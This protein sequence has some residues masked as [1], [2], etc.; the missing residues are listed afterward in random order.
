MLAHHPVTGKEVRVLQTDTSL[1]REKKT[2]AWVEPGGSIPPWDT[3]SSGRL[4]GGAWPDFLLS[5]DGL[6][7]P[8][9][10]A[11][12][13]VVFTGSDSVSSGNSLA[14]GS[15]AEIYPHLGPKWD[16]TQEDAIVLIAGL[17]RYR[18]V[19]G[20]WS[21]R[22]TALGLVQE[23]EAPLKLWWIT[24]LFRP[25]TSARRHEIT[26]C[27]RRN[28]ESPLIDRIV[29]LNE[30]PEIFPKSGK[31]TEVIVGKRLRYSTVLEWIA[32]EVPD[33][34][35]VA[36][37]NAD[38]CIDTESWCSLWSVELTGRFLALLRYDVPES[39]DVSEATL[40]GP[41]A[42]SQDT[43]VVKASDIRARGK[44]WPAVNIPFGQMGCDNAVA[45]EMM[46][47]K[48][49]VVNPAR[50]MK[51]WHFHASG[52]RTYVKTDVVDRPTF[53][54]VH[55]SG[56]NDLCPVLKWSE[57]KAGE[58]IHVG[59]R[60][61]LRLGPCFGTAD[62]LVF[63]STRT[64]VGP[65]VETQKV[66]SA[67]A[68]HGLA[69]TIQCKKGVVTPW[70][71]GAETSREL[72]VL[73]Y[74]ARI[75]RLLAV[76]D[77]SAA[78]GSAAAG[79]EFICPKADWATEALTAFKWSQG[80]MPVIEYDPQV[81]MWYQSALVFP[82][83]ETVDELEK[84]DVDTLRLCVKG[85]K[86]DVTEKYRLR[87]VIVEGGAITPGISRDL[88]DILDHAWEVRV[89]YSESSSLD[90]MRDMFA[91]AWGVLCSSGL[92][93]TGWN[94]LLPVG[95]RVFELG[96]GAGSG[97]GS[98]MAALA[99]L[100]HRKI[101]VKP[102]TSDLDTASA[103]IEEVSRE[104]RAIAGAALAAAAAL[105]VIWI[106]RRDLE[107]FFAH[108]GD[109]FREMVRLW[110][111]KGWVQVKE[112]ALATMIWWGSVGSDG[113]L[114]YDRDNQDWRLA[115]PMLEQ[116]WTRGLFGNPRPPVVGSGQT[117][118]P[119]SYWPRRP[120]LVE[121]IREQSLPGGW[122]TRPRRLVFYGKIENKVQERRRTA[123]DWS[124][125]APSA[126]DEWILV[127]GEQPYPFTQRQYLERL[128]TAKFGLCIPGYGFKCH[129]EVECMAM[130][131]VPI[132]SPDVDMDSYAVPPREGVEY[133]RAANP[134][135]AAE[136]AAAVTQSEWEMMSAAGQAWW[137]ANAS[138][139]G[140][141]DLTKKL[142]EK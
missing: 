40:F 54:Y 32:A 107:G 8:A 51:T 81:Q 142:V 47:S 2:L 57:L 41:R 119:W 31:V 113:V 19:S 129:R 117:G 9:D 7:S 67:A 128:A 92:Q 93:A 4:A 84:E 69:P 48:F 82:V 61:A 124:A 24:Q 132:V 90:R 63:D 123:A 1:W 37:A 49:L 46:R 73:R 66:W 103:M 36:F 56:F 25:T 104:K 100:E 96:S 114:L 80:T 38:I 14:L 140:L 30:K 95:A 70:P 39:E 45:I 101:V 18:R 115:A 11:N 64:F 99:G 13:K 34:V 12:V 3:V 74:L 102:G 88:E 58:L 22:G 83:G 28:I 87:L 110:G 23:S 77:G 131:C 16:G 122:E 20:A 130:G 120:E 97:A 137:A 112:H 139:Q 55:P 109:S 17:L 108:P 86:A 71:P 106:P 126:S 52:V 105:P 89:V 5:L 134:A 116:G 135:A 50:S 68:L 10:S 121:E 98:K 15:L 21:P 44:L 59:G 111:E 60:A 65:G 53:L 91:G 78:A 72:Y 125:A 33:N 26:T 42:D 43:W 76:A 75:L 127:R 79:S 29:L 27:L 85:W 35:I 141:F 136:I 138:C 133:R 6:C 62:G 118:I 94:W